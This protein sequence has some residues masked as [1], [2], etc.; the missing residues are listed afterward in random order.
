MPKTLIAGYEIRENLIMLYQPELHGSPKFGHVLRVLF[1][2]CTHPNT[3]AS[4]SSV[5]LQVFTIY[6][7]FIA[8]QD[9]PN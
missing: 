1:S 7:Q 4:P 9:E 5:S 2:L 3:K 8:S 6:N